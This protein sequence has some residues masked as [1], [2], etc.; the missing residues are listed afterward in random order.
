[1]VNTILNRMYARLAMSETPY[2]AD[3]IFVLAGL[4][5]RKRYGW[6]LFERG[7]APKM[8]VSVGRNE[9]RFLKT[10]AGLPEDGGIIGLLPLRPQDG[11][12]IFLS[13]ER[14]NVRS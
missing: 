5:E 6:S 4:P 9:A 12:H 10:R 1:M 7:F 14:H 11:N 2:P 3:L 8:L 13:A